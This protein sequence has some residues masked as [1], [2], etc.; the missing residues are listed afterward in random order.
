MWG[1]GLEYVAGSSSPSYRI[2]S[3]TE[4]WSDE[5][6]KLL[7]DMFSIQLAA[8][9]MPHS[10]GNPSLENQPCTASPAHTTQVT[11]FL[12]LPEAP[13]LTSSQLSCF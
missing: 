12:Q 8:A 5:L 2:P 10:E 3:R 9:T 7:S 13:N 11:T 4:M 6:T 1:Q